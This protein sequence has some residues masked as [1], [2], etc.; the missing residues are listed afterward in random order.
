MH[1]DCKLYGGVGVVSV[2]VPSPNVHDAQPAWLW[3]QLYQDCSVQYYMCVV[4]VCAGVISIRNSI[5]ENRWQSVCTQFP[6][7]EF[8]LI[9][10]FNSS[11]QRIMSKI[12]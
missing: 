12:S 9:F 3:R 5:N 10:L 11:I 4:I 7:S 6:I 8:Y 2:G 1:R